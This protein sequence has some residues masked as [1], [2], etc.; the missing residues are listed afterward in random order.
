[1]DKQSPTNP[2]AL[3]FLAIGTSTD[4]VS[5][6]EKQPMPTTARAAVDARPVALGTVGSRR[7]PA[8]VVVPRGC[9]DP[10]MWQA[11]VRLLERHTGD[12]SC[13][14]CRRVC[15]YAAICRA[16]LDVAQGLPTRHD[17]WWWHQMQQ[18]HQHRVRLVMPPTT[19][20]ARIHPALPAYLHHLHEH[21]APL[22]AA[23][24]AGHVVLS[25]FQPRPSSAADVFAKIYAAAEGVRIRRRSDA[26]RHACAVLAWLGPTAADN[27]NDLI[28]YPAHLA[29]ALYAP[30][31]L[32][33]ADFA[34]GPP[35]PSRRD[36][37]IPA[38][39]IGLVI[40]RVGVPADR[41]LI[42]PTTNPQLIPALDDDGHDVISATLTRSR[43][44]LTPR[45]AFRQLELHVL[46][47][48]EQQPPPAAVP[49]SA[50]PDRPARRLRRR[51]TGQP[52]Q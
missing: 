34:P 50:V 49:P 23:R 25:S 2:S 13:P 52:T 31:G 6:S 12:D 16:G 33:I 22:A 5:T 7:P 46:A 9:I 32:V 20:P 47:R 24:E 43:G 51:S 44:S 30:T 45:S 37:P 8:R 1:M 17:T 4:Q 36:Q 38:P 40:I 35:R 3:P 27:H 14:S 19:D 41:H 29:R 10:A 21:C 15:P 11:A 26:G 28:A 18:H 42:G 39:P 48:I